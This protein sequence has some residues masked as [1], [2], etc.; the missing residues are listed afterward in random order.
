MS[1]QDSGIV[2]IHG[3]PRKVNVGVNGYQRIVNI[4]G[5][6][7]PTEYI[8]R[9]LAEQAL[10]RKLQGSELVHHV[11]CNKANNDPSNLVICPDSEYHQLLHR[12]QRAIDATGDPKSVKCE[13]CCGYGAEKER[14]NRPGIGWHFECKRIYERAAYAKRQARS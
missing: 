14:P 7:G 6:N 11:D 13:Y 8:H 9:M 12:R 3:K 2:N 5:R 1:K 4:G 10:G